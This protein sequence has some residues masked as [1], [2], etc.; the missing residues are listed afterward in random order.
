MRLMLLAI[1]MLA[2]PGLGLAQEGR[3][4]ALVVGNAAYEHAVPLRNPRNDAGDLTA[5][6]KAL[7]FEVF[8]GVDLDRKS[9]VQALIRFGRAAE[10][11]EVALFFY[12]GHGLQVDGRNYLVPVDA[13]VEFAAE[14]DISLVSLDGVMQQMERGSR[15]NLVF[16]DACRN[17]PFEEQLSRSLG[18]RSAASLSKGLGRVQTGSGSFVAFATQPDAVAADGAG[19]NSPFTTALLKHIGTPGQ[20]ISDM[21]IEVRNEVMSETGGKQVPWDSSSLTGR[22]FFAPSTDRPVVDQRP[23]GPAVSPER[24]AYELAVKLGTCGAYQA[25]MRS[26]PN[27]FYAEL[28]RE[29]SAAICQPQVAMVTRQ[30]RPA[31]ICAADEDGTN[32]CATSVL[33]PIGNNRYDPS[34]LF[35]GDPATA[36]VEAEEADGLG[37]AIM[38]DFGQDRR[39]AGFEISNGY[40]KDQ[41][42]W[43]NNSRIRKLEIQTSDG[44]TINVDLPDQRGANRFDFQP[45]LT[46]SSLKMT[47][48]EVYRGAKFRDTA[49]SELRPV[50]ADKVSR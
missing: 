23:Q 7:G 30:A 40:D 49:V 28:A 17:N 15:T 3:R 36:W 37:E 6:L 11:A 24:E 5:K 32:Y 20:S 50:F 2:W 8:G 29:Q 42:T 31:D 18:H 25:F 27:S 35:D 21:M 4:V 10:Q 46:T 9:L 33:K 19:R 41:R 12:A 47:I 22:F 43:S 38:M 16:L 34:N 48:R 39:I 45:A 13:M 26:F 44:Q 1:C 14:I